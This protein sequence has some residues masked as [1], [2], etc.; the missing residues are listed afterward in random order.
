M[1]KQSLHW[2][3]SHGHDENVVVPNEVKPEKAVC[4]SNWQPMLGGTVD[5]SDEKMETNA[6]VVVV[7]VEREVVAW[8]SETVM[9]MVIMM[10]VVVV[11]VAAW[12]R[13][14]FGTKP[15]KP[16]LPPT[17]VEEERQRAWHSHSNALKMVQKKAVRG[18]E[19]DW[20][21]E[22]VWQSVEFLCWQWLNAVREWS[23]TV[24]A[25]VA[26]EQEQ[27]EAAE[28]CSVVVAEEEELVWEAAADWQR[29]P[30]QMALEDW[31]P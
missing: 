10:V 20:K 6:V 12:R 1:E 4:L 19:E 28:T 30:R 24:V 15:R 29:P 23:V 31:L 8:Q 21:G 7:V 2:P 26:A 13:I 25:A 5:V 3:E 14:A 11:V 17:T 9:M 22:E 18:V 27:V 16:P